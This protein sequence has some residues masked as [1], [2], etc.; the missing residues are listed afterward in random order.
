MMRI[1]IRQQHRRSPLL[2]AAIAS[3]ISA[4]AGLLTGYLL[5]RRRRPKGALAGTGKRVDQAMTRD[6]QAIPPLTPVSEAARLMRTQ[7]VGSVPVVDEGRLV[8]M[9]TDRDIA[10]RLVAEGKD[11]QATPVAEV[12]S[13]DVITVR[14]EQELDSA[15]QLMARHQVRRLPV[16]EN[17]RL[18]GIVAQADV[19][20]EAPGTPTARVV[21]EV[22]QPTK[23][24]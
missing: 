7:D 16:V 1:Q 18:V 13:A 21:E 15:L 23:A 17:N 14:P 10:L 9:V 8:G 5:F 19:A 20:I 3:P 22:S 2:P 12:A 6:P 11:A 4:L 24:A